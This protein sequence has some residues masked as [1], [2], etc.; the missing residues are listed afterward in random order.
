MQQRR[1]ICQL[2]G[3][4]TFWEDAVNIALFTSILASQH[5]Y[6]MNA[7]KDDALTVPLTHAISNLGAAYSATQKTLCTN[8]ATITAMQNQQQMICQT[9]WSHPPPPSMVQYYQQPAGGGQCGNQQ[10]RESG[11]GRGGGC[12]GECSNGNGNSGGGYGD[13]NGGG[14]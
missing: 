14:G 7:A 4:S 12:S 8:N 6:S 11:S 3:I 13:G 2:C 10:G 9:L 1:K 5:G